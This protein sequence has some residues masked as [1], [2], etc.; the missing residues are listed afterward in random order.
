VP[1]IKDLFMT[2]FFKSSA[3]AAVAFSAALPA[4]AATE[5]DINSMTCAQYEDLAP[6][7]RDTVAMLAISELAVDPAAVQEAEEAND[8]AKAVADTGTEPATESPVGSM[9]DSATASTTTN[10]GSDMSNYEEELAIMNRICT[11]NPTTMVMEAAAG[12]TGKR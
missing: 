8:P 2:R 7:D 10:A 9:P 3:I 1:E 4:Y 12:L 5:V 11:L 6:A